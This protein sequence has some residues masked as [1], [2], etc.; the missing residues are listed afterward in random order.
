MLFGKLTNWWTRRRKYFFVVKKAIPPTPSLYNTY[1]TAT[2]IKYQR[3]LMYRKNL[4]LILE[5]IDY[6]ASK[7]KVL[8]IRLVMKLIFLSSSAPHLKSVV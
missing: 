2:N 7:V 3:V 4:F 5:S 6:A 8:I 1:W